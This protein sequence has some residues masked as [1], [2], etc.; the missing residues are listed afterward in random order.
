MRLQEMASRA[1]GWART[2]MTDARWR[3]WAIQLEDWA[4][5]KPEQGWTVGMDWSQ[6]V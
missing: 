6:W 1:K 4:V 2:W 5:R 3:L